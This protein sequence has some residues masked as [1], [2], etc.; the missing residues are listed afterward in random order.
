MSSENI[1]KESLY[2]YNWTQFNEY[3]INAQ[4]ARFGA[5]GEELVMRKEINW[6]KI[7]S[8]LLLPILICNHLRY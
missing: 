4:Q 3:V 7:K 5:A 2:H 6:L 8:N 1:M